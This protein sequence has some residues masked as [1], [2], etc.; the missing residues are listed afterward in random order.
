[1]QMICKLSILELHGMIFALYGK[2]LRPNW[3]QAEGSILDAGGKMYTI[4]WQKPG[5][6]TVTPLYCAYCALQSFPEQ[7]M[8]IAVPV[9]AS[10]ASKLQPGLGI[11]LG[12]ELHHLDSV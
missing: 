4:A 8:L 5:H 2:T 12:V 10:K 6:R 3:T 11:A 7:A 1:M 9:Q